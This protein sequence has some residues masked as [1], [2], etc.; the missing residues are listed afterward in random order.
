M[1]RQWA[2]AL[3]P[4]AYVPASCR[5]IDLLLGELLDRLFE[6]LAVDEFSPSPGR[7][8]G[9]R[10][11]A[12]YFTGEQSLSCTVETLGQALPANPEL[13][14]VDG[15]A[16][17]VA[18]L[19]GALA[20]GY[21]A[22]L[23]ARTLD[24]QEEVKQALLKAGRDAE[25]GWHVSE[26]KFQQLFTSSAVGI[27]IS[28]LNGD[29][30]ETNQAL[31][32][33][34]G[35]LAAGCS[36]Y[37]LFHP[38]DVAPLR[39]V[40]QDLVDGRS[41]AYRLPQRIRLIDKYGEPAWTYLAVS[42]LRDA[43]GEP[44]HQV[45]IVEDVTELHLL[46][47]ALR[48]QSLHDVLTGLSNQQFFMSTLGDVLE[49]ADPASRTTVCKIDLDG[50]A[51]IN[52][53]FGRATGDRVLQVVAERLKSVVAG[54]KATV[55]RFGSDEFAIIL[56]NPPAAPG[57]AALV[58]NVNSE[59]DE[60]VH[61]D[62]NALVVF[63]CVGVV[64][65]QGRGMEA[66]TLLR[67]A[68]AAL[69]HAK[70]N[71]KRQ[72]G[73]FD[74]H[75]DADHRARCRLA[76]AM[77]GAWQ[78][79]E[80]SLHYQPLVR[81]ADSTIVGIQAL[82][83]WDHPCNGPLS[84]QECLELAARTGLMPPLGR[85]MVGSACEQLALWRQRFGAV[86]PL[87]HVDITPPQSHDP[88]LGG[89][90]RGVLEQT[91]LAAD[92]LQLGIP[93]SALDAGPGEGDDNVGALADMGVAIALLGLSGVADVAHLE[94]LPVRTVEIASPV[95]QR[96]AKRPGEG[97]AVARSVPLMLELVQCCGA[98]VMVRGLDTQDEADWWGS[99]GADVGQGAFLAPPVAP[100]EI[101]AAW[102]PR[103]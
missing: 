42:L 10:L 19:L 93:V 57:I 25:R 52:D 79:G 38:N 87:L 35:D 24:Q 76:A 31:R 6:S 86:T 16:G 60:P 77:P 89:F 44:T 12:G 23:R 72:W 98:T 92:R 7:E 3:R 32:E 66:A 40:Y 46:G 21:A 90:V 43:D 97:S 4:T 34:V 74:P 59:L 14:G 91:G 102:L 9:Q 36:L 29:L 37:E 99:V 88:G 96:V 26:A 47:Q 13:Q 18:S 56:D 71:G 65:H 84:H 20:A 28:D 70:S 55:A 69:H 103:T 11:V 82:L 50:L 39:S 83:R 8:V 67:A 73:L 94:D 81:L 101:V 51:I 63:G 75:R 27:A 17:K 80:I 41:A 54:D 15:L 2:R 62:G 49:R 58:A 33:I 95:V 48:H 85:W 5:E 78:S 100:D 45:T 53:G 1:A 22:A 68:E 61:I 30:L 64:E